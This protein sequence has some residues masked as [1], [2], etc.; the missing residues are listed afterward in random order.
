MSMAS[1]GERLA[2][3]EKGG[4][5]EGERRGLVDSVCQIDCVPLIPLVMADMQRRLW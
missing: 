5:I 2:R 3:G 4:W 1:A